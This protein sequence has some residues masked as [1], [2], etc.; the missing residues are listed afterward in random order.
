MKGES[1]NIYEVVAGDSNFEVITPRNANPANFT[2][3]TK[4]LYSALVLDIWSLH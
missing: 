1:G 3:H 2:E 4:R